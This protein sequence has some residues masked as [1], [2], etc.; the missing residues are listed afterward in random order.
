MAARNQHACVGVNEVER[1]VELPAAF[2]DKMKRLLKDEYEAFVRSYEEPRKTGLRV[3]TLKVSVPEF[4]RISPFV[5]QPVPWTNEGFFYREEDRPGKHPYHAA[6]LYYIQEPSAMAVGE[7][8]APEPGEKVLDLCAAPGGKTA[9]MA[10]RMKQQGLV[11][12]N[13]IHP[14]RARILSQNVERMGIRNAVVTNESPERLAQRFP[15]F[16]DRVLVDAPCSGEGMFR[17]DPESRAEWSEGRVRMCAVRQLDILRHAAGM[18][19]PGGRLVYS[20]CT[21]SPEENEGVI[22]Q[23]L[24]CDPRF[25]IEHV[26]GYEGF[27][28]GRAEWIEAG[29]AGDAGAEDPEGPSGVEGAAGK[30]AE[31]S[32]GVQGKGTAGEYAIRASSH[33]GSASDANRF[34][35]SGHACGAND[36]IR[37]TASSNARAAMAAA[38]SRT[39]RIWP[40][41]QPGEGHFIAVLRKT[42][43]RE[44]GRIP[45]AETMKD[46]K[47]PELFRSFAEETLGFVPEGHYMLFGEQLY[48][49]PQPMFSLRGL[50]ALRPGWHLGTF[51]KNRFEPS[52]ALALSLN[53]GQVNRHYSLRSDSPEVRAYLRGE[54]L[55]A[56]GEKGWILVDV[57]GYGLG[58]G[59]MAGGMLKNHYPKGLRKA[60]DDEEWD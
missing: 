36:A 12:A 39:V 2:L 55:A 31:G 42:G 30:A 37:F 24:L 11:V 29:L 20:T 45:M 13:E 6:G 3:N 22:S 5:L 35:A 53:A 50:K 34:H 48:L 44:Q 54:T 7:I 46:R 28:R 16:F 18:L 47:I 14:N 40:H 4:L 8:A 27:S 33:A 26:Q 21:F 17:K 38:V 23:F 43:G 60:G 58:W 56:E 59:K 19:R 52:H 49:A 25:E 32:S 15:G 41:R 1:T 51:K 9:H 10:A 57:D